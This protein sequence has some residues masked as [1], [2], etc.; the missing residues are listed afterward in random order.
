MSD[1]DFPVTP[2]PAN[3]QACGS[4]YLNTELKT[5]KLFSVGAITVC[6]SC[7]AKTAE[8]SFKDAA[9]L[10]DEIVLIASATSGNPERRLQAIK[11]LI[12]E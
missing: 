4:E 11:A 6:E 12:G 3:C 1:S 7:L 9:E 10:L 5:V 2:V 8:D